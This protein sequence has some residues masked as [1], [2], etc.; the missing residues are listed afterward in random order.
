MKDPT[1]AR[2]QGKIAR[3][4][5]LGLLASAA[6]G[7]TTFAGALS[8]R[9]AASPLPPRIQREFRGLWVATVG[10]I[11]WPSK[12][13]LPVFQQKAE[14]IAILNSAAQMRLNAIILQVRPACDAFYA[15]T[16]DPWSEYLTGQMGRPP[17]PFYDP[18]AFAV[19]EAHRRGM[20]LH[21]WFNPF[22]VRQAPVK[23][24]ISPNHISRTQPGI[25]RSIGGNL[26]WLDPGSKTAR[27]YAS[28]VILDVTRRYDIDGVHLDDYFYP[29]PDKSRPGA[30]PDDATWSQY[31]RS[32]GSLTRDD[33]RRKNVDDFVQQLYFSIKREKSWVKFGISPFGIWRPGNPSQITGLD[34]Y[35]AIYADSRKWLTQGWVDYFSP[36]LYWPIK[37]AAQSYPVLL[38][39]WS[40]QNPLQRHLW[41]GNDVA[42]AVLRSETRELANQVRLTRLQ[43]GASGNIFWNASTLMNQETRKP[44]ALVR[45]MFSEPALIPGLSWQKSSPPSRPKL[46][47][48]RNSRELSVSWAL[49]GGQPARSWVVQTLSRGRWSTKIVGTAESVASWK[50]ASRKIAPEAIAVTA[51]NHFGS[52]G[53][54]AVMVAI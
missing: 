2:P 35:A 8:N 28:S 23:H 34:S 27:D 22:R 19:E 11:D 30:F 21:A 16:F 31:V 17:E 25:V 33:W 42:R 20:E 46:N 47:L 26:L 9:T 45:D 53:P 1:V 52:V 37:P 50:G 49:E 12:P 54:T 39:W 24:P 32:G 44:I 38:K 7:V 43:R 4:A 29:Y 18:L 10:N 51:V 41:P 48:T 15:S 6:G 14:F 36:Q 40:E 3:R 13:G 5:F